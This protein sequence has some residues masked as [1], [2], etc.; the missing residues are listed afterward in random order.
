MREYYENYENVQG[1][2][3]GELLLF[4][5]MEPFIEGDA[6]QLRILNAV[7]DICGSFQVSTRDFVK[8]ITYGDFKKRRGISEVMALGLRLFILF[9]CGVDWISSDNV[10]RL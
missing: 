7:S 8:L 3:L 10:K 2:G 6:R 1:L 9:E 5:G 4:G